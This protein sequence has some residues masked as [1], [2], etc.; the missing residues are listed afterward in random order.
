VPDT[1]P[2]DPAHTPWSLPKRLLFRF[3]LLYF[4][5]YALP[6]PFPELW[7]TFGGMLRE[8]GVDTSQP[9]WAWT[10]KVN[11]LFYGD[12]ADQSAVGVYEGCWQGLTS[13]AGERIG[14]DVIHQPTGSGDTAHDLLKLGL[15]AAIALLLTV[16]WSTL[17]SLLGLRRGHPGLAKG[18]HLAVRWYLAFVLLGYGII[19]LYAG[20]FSYPSLYRL[21]NPIG[22]TSPMG[23]VWTFMGFSKPYEVFSGLGECLAGLLLFSRRTSLLGCLV[24]IAV[25]ANVA[26]INWAYDV[27]VKLFSTNLL[28]FAAALTLPD[29]RRLWCV[30][31]ANCPAPPADVRLTRFTWLN[32][33]LVV[34]GTVWVGCH[35]YLAHQGNMQVLEQRTETRPELHGLWEVEKMVLGGAEVAATDPSRWKTLAVENGGRVWVRTAAGNMQWLQ[36]AAGKDPA[37]LSVAPMGKDV[38][39]ADAV[40]WAVERGEKTV[41]TPMPEPRTFADYGVLVDVTRPS[42][43]LRGPWQGSELELH[44]VQKQLMLERGF[45]LVQEIPV[46]R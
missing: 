38:T 15:S 9:S 14:L 6:F 35:L 20:Q 39:R 44:L 27:P 45:H 13:A 7:S 31:V 46:N 10:G 17:W 16:S 19:K 5:L 42:L 11:E 40:D 41:K 23:L 1:L 29:L 30:F 12:P 24:A 3:A 37:T 22:D 4:A 32:A 8:L 21:A 33:A 28:L 25:M 2:K 34:F 36:L 18:L 43:V 26:M